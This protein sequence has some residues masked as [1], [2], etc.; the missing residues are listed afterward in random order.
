M[1]QLG[2]FFAEMDRLSKKKKASGKPQF[3]LGHFFAEMDRLAQGRVG[4]RQDS[5]FNWAT[6]SQKWIEK[7]VQDKNNYPGEY[8]FQLGHFFAEMD[9]A[10]ILGLLQLS[11]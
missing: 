9:R 6:S 5:C 8:A 1:F 4:P 3:Q 11:K 2:H 7:M 10:A